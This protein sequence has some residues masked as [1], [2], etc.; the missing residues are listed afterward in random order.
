MGDIVWDLMGR[1][2]GSTFYQDQSVLDGCCIYDYQ[3]YG[4][5]VYASAYEGRLWQSPNAINWNVVLDYYDGNMW[6]LEAFQNKLYMSYN[7]GELRAYDGTGDLRG[8]VVYT[9]TD[10]IISM[11]TGG[12]YLYFGS[13]G[14]A[15]DLGAENAGIASVYRYDGTSVELISN[16]D[17]MVTGVQV[18]YVLRQKRVMAECIKAEILWK[19]SEVASSSVDPSF[20]TLA[21][22]YLQVALQEMD[23]AI[24]DI[25]NGWNISAYT[26][27]SQAKLYLYKFE[28]LINLH[29][30]WPSP[31]LPKPLADQ[32]LQQAEQIVE[33]INTALNT[34]I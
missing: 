2:D 4:G 34:A 16:V 15:A 30:S 21:D 6:E 12:R 3:D 14:A 11:I 23:K 17:E 1:W 29:M 28:A 10:G 26:H 19:K 32:W 33:E 9:A 31:K 25:I 18:L 7:N 22:A 24:A 27:L 20:K 5:Y 13:G 8:S